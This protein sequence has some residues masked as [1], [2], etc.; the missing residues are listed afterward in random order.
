MIFFTYLGI[1]TVRDIY[2]YHVKDDDMK[3]QKYFFQIFLSDLIEN[4]E[5][6]NNFR[7]QDFR[8]L[9]LKYLFSSYH[10]N[11]YPKNRESTFLAS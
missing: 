7:C 6:E 10:P 2:I 11:L 8:R 9:R 1:K 4:F 3:F 5:A